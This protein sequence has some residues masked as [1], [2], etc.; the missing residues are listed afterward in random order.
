MLGISDAHH[1]RKMV[2]GFCMIMA[3][4][5]VLV[6]EVIRPELKSDEAAQFAVVAQNMDSWASSHL[7][8]FAATVL[9]V[10]AALGL[11]HMLRERQVAWGHMGG[12]M[13][14]MGLM[15]IAGGIGVNMVVWQMAAGSET[16]M[17]AVL[18]RLTG[19]AAFTIPFMVLPLLAGLGLI[20]LAMGLYR[21]RVVQSWMAACLAVAGALFIV[22]GVAFSSTFGVVASAVLFVGLGSI[23][24]MVWSES[25]DEWVHTPEYSGFRALPGIN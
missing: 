13:L 14:L 22:E 7:I 9:A 23:G 1:F 12:G 16:E 10:P 20:V 15:A 3:P 5:L 6:G 8:M 24:R 2:A 19:D 21:A 17:V 11:M 4:L 25:D 18:E